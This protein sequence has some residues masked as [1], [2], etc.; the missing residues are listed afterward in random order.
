MRD[1]MSE[2]N[3]ALPVFNTEG[4]FTVSLK[5][6]IDFTKWVDK[7]VDKLTDNRIKILKEIHQNK[8]ISKRELE[9]KIG[10]SAT[11]IDNNLNFLKDINLLERQGTAKTGHWKIHYILP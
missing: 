2:A 8:K 1:L 4:V 6:P 3:L 10:I 9:E 7:W 11:A 5:R